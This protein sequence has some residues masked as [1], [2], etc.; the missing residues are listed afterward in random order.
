MSETIYL[1]CGSAEPENLQPLTKI[2]VKHF[3][4]ICDDVVVEEQIK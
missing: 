3:C 4:A 1:Y 2:F